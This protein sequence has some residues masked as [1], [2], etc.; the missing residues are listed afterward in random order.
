MYCIYCGKQISDKAL[1]CEYCGGKYSENAP[2]SPSQSMGRFNLQ[3]GQTDTASQAAQIKAEM[4]REQMKPDETAFGF[5]V[6]EYKRKKMPVWVPITIC[7]AVAVFCGIFIMI[8]LLSKNN[9]ADNNKQQPG[10]HSMAGL[11]ED[12]AV[13]QEAA[14]GREDETPLPDGDT[15]L[16]EEED[17]LQEFLFEPKEGECLYIGHGSYPGMEDLEFSFILSADKSFIYGITIKVTNMN[18]SVTSGNVTTNIEVSKAIERFEGEHPI[19]YQSGTAEILLGASN[20]AYLTFEGSLA[21]L[22]LDYTYVFRGVNS[23]QLQVPFGYT[24]MELWTE[25]EV[26]DY[27]VPAGDEFESY[28]E[29]AAETEPAPEILANETVFDEEKLRNWSYE[30]IESTYGVPG[31]NYFTPSSPKP[32]HYIV[33]ADKVIDPETWVESEGGYGNSFSRHLP[34]ST[35]D[36]LRTSGNLLDGGLTLTDNPDEATYVL[37]L[38]YDY[39]SNNGSFYYNDGTV[40]PQYHGTLNAELKNLITGEYIYSETKTG[41]AT[42]ANEMVYTAMLDNAKGKQLYG[43]TISLYADDF[44]GYWDFVND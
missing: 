1:F 23:E 7:S 33:C 21:W 17:T 27:P 18:A 37:V 25:D 5:Q 8:G 15:S 6:S 10:D 29:P 44:E 11:T 24:Y 30:E 13:S 43:G 28:P 31:I 22:E 40:I 16:P 20:R 39:T 9:S 41:Y 36:L 14:I 34:I 2:L 26:T 19:S 32:M 3:Y 4:P 35:E 12:E 38:H 42:Y